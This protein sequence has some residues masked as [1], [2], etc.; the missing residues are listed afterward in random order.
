LENIDFSASYWVFRLLKLTKY[1]NNPSKY[2]F[3]SSEDSI[4]PLSLTEVHLCL[5]EIM[6]DMNVPMNLEGTHS[7][8]HSVIAFLL[9]NNIPIKEILNTYRLRSCSRDFTLNQQYLKFTNLLANYLSESPNNTKI[10]NP[11]NN[12]SLYDPS[13]QFSNPRNFTDK[14]RTSSKHQQEKHIRNR[15]SLSLISSISQIKIFNASLLR[16]NLINFSD[17][18]ISLK[19]L[20]IAFYSIKIA[21]SLSHFLWNSPYVTGVPINTVFPSLQTP[22]LSSGTLNPDDDYDI[23]SEIKQSV[24]SCTFPQD[25]SSSPSAVRTDS[26]IPA[27]GDLFK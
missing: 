1:Y 19:I 12:K 25:S 17:N 20:Q 8:K 7:F 22:S 24:E 10:K 3:I 5:Q 9:S 26:S 15:K 27:D 6:Q 16:Q 4:Y 14:I 21:K 23:P 2:L 18:P 13:P 11:N